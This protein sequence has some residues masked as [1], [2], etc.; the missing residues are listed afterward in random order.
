[1]VAN[2]TANP[3]PP[4]VPNSN[5]TLRGSPHVNQRTGA[6]TFMV[7]V[8]DPGTLRWL[9][10]FKNGTFGV[11]VEHRTSC[12]KSQVKLRGKC[13]SAQVVFGNGSLTVAAAGTVSF[14]VTPSA[15]ARRALQAAPRKGRGLTVSAVVSF[16]ASG[17]RP[18]SHTYS[19]TDRLRP[20]GRHSHG[21]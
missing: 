6:I 21:R 1:V 11:L 12:R 20:T 14:T 3:P 13:R 9:L 16:Q 17:G 19:L 2:F 18:A 4:P 5:F 8:S 7:S 15:A 10:T